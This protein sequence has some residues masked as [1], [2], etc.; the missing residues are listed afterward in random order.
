MLA[1][2]CDEET[3][4]VFAAMVASTGT[5]QSR[6]VCSQGRTMISTTHITAAGASRKTG[7]PVGVAA[8]ALRRL[9][10]CGLA[11]CGD[12]GEGWRTDL[13]AITDAARVAGDDPPC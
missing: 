1:L 4:L 11:R 10:R 8:E 12:G 3:L 5:G 2:L 13:Q 6:R 7:L 9:E